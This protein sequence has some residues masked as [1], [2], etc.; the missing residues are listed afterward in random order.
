MAEEKQ[1]GLNITPEMI[2]NL[3]NMLKSNSSSNT[4]NS[5]DTP[6]N[7]SA[8]TSSDFNF[9]NTQTS[10]SANN[11]SNQ[12]EESSPL[13]GIDFDTIL[14]IKTI[15]ETLNQKD[16]PRSKLLYSLK[17][18]LRESKK[19]KL[20]QYINLLKIS[21]IGEIFKKSKGDEN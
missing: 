21:Q 12:S 19:Q 10:S 18:Y 9:F 11:N 4:Q 17:P 7:T 2:Q 6:N 13:G 20:D 5:N 3:A 16:D 8:D 1:S 14:K 15:M